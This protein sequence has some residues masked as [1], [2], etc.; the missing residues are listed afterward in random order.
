MCWE[1]LEAAAMMLQANAG[2]ATAASNLATPDD[3][4][5]AAAEQQGAGINSRG[6]ASAHG[7]GGNG[8]DDIWVP[9]VVQQYVPHTE[10]LYKQVPQPEEIALH[11]VAAVLAKR[12]RLSLFNF[13]VVVPTV[14]SADGI[15]LEL[16]VVDVNYFPGVDKLPGWQ[17]ALAEH[18]QAAAG[19]A[20]AEA[21]AAAT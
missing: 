13:D 3:G 9:L 11:Y 10:E 8:S 16:C 14:Q 1:E 21:G 5:H 19:R 17:A 20:G 15:A 2:A 4:L 18:L 12:M 6:E 7:N